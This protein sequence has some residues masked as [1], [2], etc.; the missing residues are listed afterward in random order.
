MGKRTGKEI[1]AQLIRQLTEDLAKGACVFGVLIHDEAGAGKATV[2]GNYKP[3][4]PR[5][6]LIII[7]ALN[8][9]FQ[10]LHP[11]GLCQTCDEIA[12]SI[13]TAAE[14]LRLNFGEHVAQK[15]AP[16]QPSTDTKH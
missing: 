7:T 14:F 6:M 15:A 12:V 8:A 2:F 1:N 10:Q 13:D 16:T 4:T 3:I 11:Y 9:T 5:D